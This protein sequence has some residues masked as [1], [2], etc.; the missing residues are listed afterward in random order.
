MNEII[1]RESAVIIFGISARAFNVVAD[2]SAGRILNQTIK[3]SRGINKYESILVELRFDD[4]C[5][6]GHESFA[7]TGEIRDSRIRRDNGIVKCGC[8]HDEII[9]HFPEFSHL[10]KWYLC[11]TDGPMHYIANTCYLAG[12]IDYNGLAA[13]EL[14]AARLAAIW[15]D[16]TD[17]ELSAPRAVLEETLK[18]RLPAL[19]EAFKADM[20]ACGFLW[21]EDK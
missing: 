12:D 18:A 9:T 3:A 5:K 2:T 1:K 17:D 11:G 7:I 8:I 6:N 16:A 21:P 10:I 14:D 20:L 19:L 4:N 13:G 15:P